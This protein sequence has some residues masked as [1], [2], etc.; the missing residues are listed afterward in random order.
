MEILEVDA[1]QDC[2][3][4]SARLMD[5]GLPKGVLVAALERGEEL[6]LPRGGD[7]IMVGDRLLIVAKSELSTKLNEFLE[8]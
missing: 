2:R 7:Q 5:V 1:S 4:T 3:L 6:L 8:P